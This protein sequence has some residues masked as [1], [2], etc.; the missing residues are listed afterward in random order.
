MKSFRRERRRE[1]FHGS[2]AERRGA[3]IGT[4]RGIELRSL[5]VAEGL[6]DWPWADGRAA[7]SGSGLL[8]HRLSQEFAL[9]A[10][11]SRE[12]AQPLLRRETATLG[13]QRHAPRHPAPFRE[14]EAP[15][16]AR[17]E[18]RGCEEDRAMDLALR[19]NRVRC[20][21][22]DV[23]PPGEAAL[24]PAAP[25]GSPAEQ[26]SAAS[27]AVLSPAAPAGSQPETVTLRIGERSVEIRFKVG[28][29]DAIRDGEKALTLPAL[30]KAGPGRGE[31]VVLVDH[32]QLDTRA[33]AL[34]AAT[35]RGSPEC[36]SYGYWALRLDAKGVGDAGGRGASVG[37]GNPRS[38]GGAGALV[39]ES[40]PTNSA[41]RGVQ[42]TKA[43][44]VP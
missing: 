17:L 37:G 15:A 14:G 32:A 31:D 21:G 10:E 36:G 39:L 24:S 5:F 11:S 41:R 6:V 38:R 42:L 26:S 29:V 13:F 33:Y 28:G 23:V 3:E 4:F 8:A 16:A 40:R 1:R 12:R 35:T 30:K 25:A 22:A 20:G 44:W 9:R 7:P 2:D 19:V 27:G 43:R 18:W 34:F